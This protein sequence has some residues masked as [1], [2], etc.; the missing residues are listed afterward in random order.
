MKNYLLTILT[1][2]L[3]SCSLS[4]GQ[5]IFSHLQKYLE[6]AVGVWWLNG[7]VT[8][9]WDVDFK[10]HAPENTSIECRLEKAGTSECI[11]FERK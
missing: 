11:K 8:R 7:N 2:T 5:K 9:V 6:L 3:V 1:F 4:F 10:L